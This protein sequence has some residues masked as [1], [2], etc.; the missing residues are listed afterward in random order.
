MADKKTFSVWHLNNTR[1]ADWTETPAT[2]PV[3]YTK[4]AQLEGD[5]L[6]DVFRLTNSINSPWWLVLTHD[7]PCAGL[8]SSSVGDVFEV[9]GVGHRIAA[10]G[11]EA[12]SGHPGI[13][14]GY[15]VSGN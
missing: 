4:V 11:F 13:V 7:V 14:H 12:V 6:E 15:K 5:D 1:D 9:E 3:G 8:R 2:W 10:G